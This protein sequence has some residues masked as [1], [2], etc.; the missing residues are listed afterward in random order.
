MSND[1]NVIILPYYEDNN[2]NIFNIKNIVYPTNNPPYDFGK[3]ICSS[4]DEEFRSFSDDEYGMNIYQSRDNPNVGYRI[5]RGLMLFLENFYC[6]NGV[7]DAKIVEELQKRQSTIKLSKFPTGVVSINKYV[8]GQEMAFYE[9]SETIRS[10][11]INQKNNQNKV[12]IVIDVYKKLLTILKELADNGIY[13][14]DIHGGNFLV[15][16]DQKFDVNIIDFD[17]AFMSFD[18]FPFYNRK[19]M[20]EL[21]TNLL[22]Y[23]NEK[24]DIDYI[25]NNISVD[26]PIEDAFEKVLLMEQK[27][28]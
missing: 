10:F 22:N 26:N 5:Y 7:L 18:E 4:H 1:K 9:N 20:Q 14:F 19:R 13:Y 6:Y 27:I 24:A 15:S 2:G 12:K 3:Y 8:I 16:K 21:L 17:K 28:K 11:A 23:T 25:F